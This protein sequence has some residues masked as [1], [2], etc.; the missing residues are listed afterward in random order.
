MNCPYCNSAQ[1]FGGGFECGRGPTA[2]HPRTVRCRELESAALREDIRLLRARLESDVAIYRH[3]IDRLIAAGE[4]MHWAL[5][6]PNDTFD[7]SVWNRWREVR[8]AART[9]QQQGT[10]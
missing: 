9:A 10:P 4:K 8:D 7:E 1:R 2:Y 5:M 6:H 3:K